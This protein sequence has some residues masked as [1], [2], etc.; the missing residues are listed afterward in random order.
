MF[1]FILFFS[2]DLREPVYS[3][4]NAARQKSH[5]LD[6]IL[7]G[8][9]SVRAAAFYTLGD[10]HNLAGGI[11][12]ALGALIGAKCDIISYSEGGEVSSCDEIGKF[13][14]PQFPVPLMFTKSL[15][16]CDYESEFQINPLT[17]LK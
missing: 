4:I 2:G 17:Y 15:L 1:S 7:R 5:F 8:L 14:I 12:E 13:P 16:P 9:F 6:V 3:L 10:Y 11:M